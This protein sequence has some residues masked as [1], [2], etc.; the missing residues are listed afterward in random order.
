MDFNIL[1]RLN[2][3]E[4]V[5]NIRESTI[6]LVNAESLVSPLMFVDVTAYKYDGISGRQDEKVFV[7]VQ[8][9]NLKLEKNFSTTFCGRYGYEN[10][11]NLQYENLNETNSDGTKPFNSDLWL[12]DC[13]IKFVGSSIKCSCNQTGFVGVF[14]IKNNFP[15][16]EEMNL[17]GMLLRAVS[18][19]ALVL[20]ILSYALFK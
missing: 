6:K 16:I 3:K 12:F 15:Y 13:L 7:E 11:V 8:F 18:I 9:N 4:L 20:T 5:Q 10:L 17:A 2:C 14:L 19:V 1:N